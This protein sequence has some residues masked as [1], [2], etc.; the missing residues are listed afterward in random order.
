MAGGEGGSVAGQLYKQDLAKLVSALLLD[1]VFTQI[2]LVISFV[3][4]I[5]KVHMPKYSLGFYVIFV[6]VCW[7]PAV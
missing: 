7:S 5:Q 4:Q 1:T 3:L 6:W 2:L